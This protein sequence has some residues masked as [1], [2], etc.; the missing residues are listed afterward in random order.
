[1]NWKQIK[2][3]KQSTLFSSYTPLPPNSTVPFL[4]PLAKADPS[5]PSQ[6]TCSDSNRMLAQRGESVEQWGRDKG[7]ALLLLLP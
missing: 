3:V 7:A 1:M 2:M 6:N 5:W 4:L